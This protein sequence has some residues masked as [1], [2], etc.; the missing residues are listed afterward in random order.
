[1]S[2][3]TCFSRTRRWRSNIFIT[4]RL[5]AWTKGSLHLLRYFTMTYWSGLIY[6]IET[7]ILEDFPSLN[8]SKYYCNN[9]NN[10]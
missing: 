9:C 7:I 1:M 2:F 4:G 10:K 5:P 8:N 3:R 6:Y